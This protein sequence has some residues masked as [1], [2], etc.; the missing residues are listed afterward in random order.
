MMGAGG[1]EGRAL[2]ILVLPFIPLVWSRVCAGLHSP[3]FPF[4]F[5]FSITMSTEDTEIQKGEEI[6]VNIWDELGMRDVCVY[7]SVCTCTHHSKLPSALPPVP[8][9]LI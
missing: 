8:R 9:V 7:V 1:E 2:D 5:Y 6:I 3:L 4:S